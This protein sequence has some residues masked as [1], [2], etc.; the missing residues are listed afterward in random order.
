M[1]DNLRELLIAEIGHFEES[2]WRNEETGEKRFNFF[3]SLV[4][5]VV[6]GLAALWTVQSTDASFLELR[7]QIIW[8][9]SL[10]LL[11]F[12]FLSYLRM[13][14]RDRVTDGFRK[15]LQDIREKYRRLLLA[16]Y[17]ELREYRLPL[18]LV[19]PAWMPK[20]LR[21]FLQAGYTQSLAIL[22]GILLAATLL[23]SGAVN[24]CAA[25]VL[26]ALLAIVL[27]GIAGI[28]HPD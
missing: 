27:A 20:S 12:G 24:G 22:N 18:K 3:I 11:I 13:I 8:Q 6:A 15:T 25:A 10:A 7:E 28:A 4:T 26:G 1:S 21:R 14:H 2:A 9:A 16:E 5:A 17:P 23:A 19:P